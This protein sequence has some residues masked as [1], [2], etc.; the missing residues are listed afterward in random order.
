MLRQWWDAIERLTVPRALPVRLELCTM[1]CCPFP[2][3]AERPVWQRPAENLQGLDRYRCIPTGVQR[4]KMRD[5]MFCVVHRDRDSVE[6]ADPRHPEI[7]HDKPD[8]HEPT[9]TQPSIEPQGGGSDHRMVCATPSSLHFFRTDP[10]AA[11][12]ALEEPLE[13]RHA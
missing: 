6:L 11:A 4:V 7:V 5:A 3:E 8:E 2:H 13:Q 12:W 9:E 10:P 1:E